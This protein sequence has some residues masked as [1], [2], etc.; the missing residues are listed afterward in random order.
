MTKKT[1]TGILTATLVFGMA[2]L[3][4]AA[5]GSANTAGVRQFV[6]GTGGVALR[7]FEA[8]AP[9]SQARISDSHGVLQLTLEPDRYSWRFQAVDSGAA[10]DSGSGRCR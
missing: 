9:G 2:S 8:A 5:D 4:L 6:V 1:L 10:K 7:D 3:A